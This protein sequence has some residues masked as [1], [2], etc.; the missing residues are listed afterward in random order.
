MVYLLIGLY[1]LYFLFGVYVLEIMAKIR[2]QAMETGNLPDPVNVTS[3]PSD[4][5]P[6]CMELL[7]TSISSGDTF[8]L[9]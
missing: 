3:L 2:S 6:E 1:D 4:D 8:F 5:S 7:Q 9:D